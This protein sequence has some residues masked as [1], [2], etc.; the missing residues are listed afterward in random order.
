[1]H[2]EQDTALQVRNPKN[3]VDAGGY[4]QMSF[5]VSTEAENG[6]LAYVGSDANLP[7]VS[8]SISQFMKNKYSII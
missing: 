8:L 5:Y 1:M 6:F 4:T 3:I 7:A 2:F